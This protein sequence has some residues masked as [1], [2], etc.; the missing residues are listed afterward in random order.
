MSKSIFTKPLIQLILYDII[1][2]DANTWDNDSSILPYREGK[3]THAYILLNTKK[4]TKSVITLS[5]IFI[6][7]KTLIWLSK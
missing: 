4:Y 2:N 5:K 7:I 6:Y 1:P 3:G